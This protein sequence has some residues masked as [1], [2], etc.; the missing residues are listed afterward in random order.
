MAIYFADS[1]F[2]IALVD[3]RDAHHAQAVDWSLNTSG[4]IVTT[5]AVV[6]ETVNTFSRPIWRDRAI[7]LIEHIESRDD[8]EIVP[9]SESLWNRGWKLF[10]ERLDKAWSL[11]DCIS[12]ELMHE[13]R[14]REALTADSHFQQAGFRAL[15]V[16]EP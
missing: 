4:R 14:V 10:R 3:Q 8:I 12:F 9:F 1:S 6:L 11:T 7:A 16:A 2:W 13:R 15:F 5:K